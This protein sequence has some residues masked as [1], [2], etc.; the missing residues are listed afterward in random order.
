MKEIV[1]MM[2]PNKQVHKIVWSDFDRQSV[3]TT[4][5]RAKR[6]KREVNPLSCQLLNARISEFKHNML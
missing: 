6:R 2:E 3:A 4:T 1:R 5:R